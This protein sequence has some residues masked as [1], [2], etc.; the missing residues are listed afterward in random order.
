MKEKFGVDLHINLWDLGVN[1]ST[2][3]KPFIDIGLSITAFRELDKIYFQIPFL[4]KR[5]EIIE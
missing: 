3:V 2:E 4:L 5:E 1:K